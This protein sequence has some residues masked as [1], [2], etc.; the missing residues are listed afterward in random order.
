MPKSILPPALLGLRAGADD[1]AKQLL[2]EFGPLRIPVGAPGAGHLL[3]MCESTLSALASHLRMPSP[4]FVKSMTNFESLAQAFPPTPLPG[5]LSSS[6]PEW[7]LGIE[8]A[9]GGPLE[10]QMMFVGEVLLAGTTPTRLSSKVLRLREA[11]T[12]WR[13]TQQNPA[14]VTSSLAD[15]LRRLVMAFDRGGMAAPEVRRRLVSERIA[16]QLRQQVSFDDP[17]RGRLV[18]QG[19]ALLDEEIETA[20]RAL[21]AGVEHGDLRCLL[22]AAAY[23]IGLLIDDMLDMPFDPR[24]LDTLQILLP[25]GLTDLDLS[26]ALSE[27]DK[28]QLPGTVPAGRRLVRHMPLLI[29]EGLY[30]RRQSAAGLR[31]Y[32]ELLGQAQLRSWDP[33]PFV[34]DHLGPRITIARLIQSRT[35]YLVRRHM[36]PLV[37]G[38][39][40]LRFDH[41]PKSIHPYSTTRDDE[42]WRAECLRAEIV[43]FGPLVPRTSRIAVGSTT[44]PTDQQIVGALEYLEQ[45]VEASRPWKKASPD[46]VIAFHK[47]YALYMAL[48]VSFFL[49]FREFAVFPLLA[50]MLGQTQITSIRHKVS[51][52][53]QVPGLSIFPFV[54]V[55][56]RRWISHCE[57]LDVRIDTLLRRYP[58]HPGLLAAKKH[59]KALLLRKPV[60]LLFFI[61]KSTIEPLGTASLQL[62]L[63]PQ[64]RLAEDAGRHWLF[65]SLRTHGL[66]DIEA[67]YVLQH[68]VPGAELL[69]SDS[70]RSPIEIRARV[71]AAHQRAVMQLRVS[72]AKGFKP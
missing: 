42:L 36:H 54:Q 38:F 2:Q 41:L 10:L 61:G 21:R 46:Q 63:P 26:L 31:F 23:W 20:L 64:W 45:K 51:S 59:V 55:L 19:Q 34:A 24:A 17:H 57:S 56:L 28:Q 44:T 67:Q 65:D 62:G 11:L 8:L 30:E 69:S 43:G 14:W 7:T 49:A 53:K 33:V 29:A 1:A 39:T 68:I 6:H 58:N 5:H 40:T 37:A 66:S 48:A 22:V 50:S 27:L 4:K 52:R 47:A 32:G 25:E 35:A 13:Q 3:S 71:A 15:L 70:S 16:L 18:R 60:R 12:Q 9:Q 72:A